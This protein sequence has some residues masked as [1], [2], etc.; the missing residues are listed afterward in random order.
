MVGTKG[1][2]MIELLI[3]FIIVGLLAAIAIPIYRVNIKKVA[4]S[5]GVALLGTVLTAQ[6]VYYSE[7]NT[8]TSNENILGI[9]LSGNKYF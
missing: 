8:Y 4:S 9:D 1:F 6:K 3:V 7:D 5:E 2:T